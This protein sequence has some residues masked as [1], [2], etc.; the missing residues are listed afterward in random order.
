[1]AVATMLSACQALEQPQAV[2]VAD[3]AVLFTASLG[4]DTKT[5]LEWDDTAQVYKTI[6]ST[7]DA[8][9]ILARQSD[10]TY[11]FDQGVLIDGAGTSKGLFSGSLVSDRYIAYYGYGW[12]YE[13]GVVETA[14]Q[15]Y[16]GSWWDADG[17]RR[18]S[19][20]DYH[21]PMYAMSSDRNLSFKNLASVLKIGLTGDNVYIDNVVVTPN[22]PSL[23]IAGIADIS[24]DEVGIPSL[25]MRNDSTARRSVIY[26]LCDTLNTATP[27]NC[28]IVL[29]PQTYKGGFTIT[30]NSPTGSMTRTVTEDVTFERSQIRAMSTIAYVEE[31]SLSWGLVGTMND[32]DNDLP[33]TYKDGVWVIENVSLT[34]D[35]EFKLRADKSWAVNVG[36]DGSLVT[37]DQNVSLMQDGQNMRVEKEGVYTIIFDSKTYTAIFRLES[38]AEVIYECKSYADVLALEDESLVAIKGNVVG[39]YKR[40]FIINIENQWDNSILVY[41]GSDQSMY[42]PV[43]GNEVSVIA[44]KKIYNGLPE[45][46]TVKS[47]EVLDAAESDPGYSWVHDL[48]NPYV[49]ASQELTKYDYVKYVGTLEQSGTYNNV[50]VDGITSRIGSLEFP[51]QDITEYI[52]KKVVIEGWFIGF[53]GGGKYLKT[54]VKKISLP[55]GGDGETEDVVPGDDIVVPENGT[56]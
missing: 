34:P 28:Y 25:Q 52:G 13:N 22:D 49:F 4:A 12:R 6:W 54:V 44:Y 32:W 9:W 40:G 43:L 26:R 21:Y 38:A 51:S 42:V 23:A 14:M 47:I 19:F 20:G 53:S 41:Q 55:E 46:H 30:V 39:V 11:A 15:E 1:M 35:D 3:D 16:Q 37:P 45:L 50:T 27:Q 56:K 18:D 31:N 33:L 24:I 48:L 5:S 29:P 10:G 2:T 17:S 7:G 8:I 36:S